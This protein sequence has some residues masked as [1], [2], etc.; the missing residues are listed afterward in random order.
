MTLPLATENWTMLPCASKIRITKASGSKQVIYPFVQI[1]ND[2][3]EL[4]TESGQRFWF[5]WFV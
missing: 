5:T 4:T 2:K 1:G 3:Y